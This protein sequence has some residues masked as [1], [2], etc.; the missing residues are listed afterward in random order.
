MLAHTQ[1]FR[2]REAPRIDTDRR[3]CTK[4]TD[5]DRLVDRNT[6]DA[7]RSEENVQGGSR[8]VETFLAPLG[9]RVG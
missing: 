4:Q 2:T 5:T 3:A 1:Q 9:R 7:R 8:S 6:Q